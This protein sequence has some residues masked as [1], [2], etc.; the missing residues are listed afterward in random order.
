MLWRIGNTSLSSYLP[1]FITLGNSSTIAYSFGTPAA[2]P[3]RAILFTILTILRQTT[4]APQGSSPQY[5]QDIPTSGSSA[6]SAV[7]P[8][9]VC[10]DASKPPKGAQNL[11]PAFLSY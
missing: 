4:A 6:D 1:S 3:I 11:S 2:M 9:G 7:S 5:P 10:V 8:T